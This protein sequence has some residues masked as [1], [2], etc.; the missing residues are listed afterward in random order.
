MG[1]S[2]HDGGLVRAH[3]QAPSA[4]HVT[5]PL[6]YDW[7]ASPRRASRTRA[8]RSG[9]TEAGSTSRRFSRRSGSSRLPSASPREPSSPIRRSTSAPRG[10]PRPS[11]RSRPDGSN[12]RVPG[13]A[14]W[15]GRPFVKWFVGGALNASV[16]C[17]DRHVAAGGG[18]GRLP[19]GGRARRHEGDHV[20][21][22]ARGGLPPR[23]RPALAR[24]RATA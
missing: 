10:T 4:S 11:G 6:P 7:R 2:E 8:G 22:A 14:C 21:A 12:G 19:L 5:G 1:G 24:G 23:E 3:M 16:N 20:R 13:P 9:V 15:S 17:L 18:Q